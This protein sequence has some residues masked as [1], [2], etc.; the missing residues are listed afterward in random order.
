M[1]KTIETE[2]LVLR[3]FNLND[4]NDIYEYLAE[5]IVNCF[6]D[7]KIKSLQEAEKVIQERIKN[8][9]S[10]IY[11]VICLKDTGKVIGELFAC[12]DEHE[13]DTFS[14]CWML[15]TGY[16]K[17]GYDYESVSACFNYLFNEIFARRIYVYTEDY[18]IACQKLCEKLNM[19]KEG[20][21][22]NSFHLLIIWT[23]LRNTKTLINMPY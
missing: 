21:F 13:K 14:P 15:N 7:M 3:N 19:R 2:R 17:Q 1:K 18:N 8:E 12:A 5:P 22:K 11:F 23:G 10:E 16:Q 20:L 4:A 6:M 9:K